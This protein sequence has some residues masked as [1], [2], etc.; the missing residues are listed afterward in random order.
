MFCITPKAFNTINMIPSF[1]STK[2]FSDHYMITSNCQRSISMPIIGVVQTSR[3]SMLSN[4]SSQLSSRSTLYRKRLDQSVPLQ[5][6]ENNNFACSS[7]ASFPFSVPTKGRIVAFNGP[8]K[9]Y[10]TMFFIGTAGPC[11][12]EET[13][14]RRSRGNTFETHPVNRNSQGKKLNKFSFCSVGKTTAFPHQFNFKPRTTPTAFH[15]AIS[16]FPGSRILT[17]CTSYHN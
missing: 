17:F 1:G 9:R 14:N 16:K 2:I 8:F 10:P 11:Q 6:P 12:S 3:P 5:N 15:S 7:P 13:F 4:K